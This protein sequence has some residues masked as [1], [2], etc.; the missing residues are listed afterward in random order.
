MGYGAEWGLSVQAVLVFIPLNLP[1]R[2]P[3][4]SSSSSLCSAMPGGL[5]PVLAAR[6]PSRKGAGNTFPTK[7]RW[8]HPSCIPIDPKCG[9]IRAGRPPKR[10]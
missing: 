1:L 2:N 3:T 10:G 5:T 7:N 4:A 8:L 6:V 9:T